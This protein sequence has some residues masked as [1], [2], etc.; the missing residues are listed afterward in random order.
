MEQLYLRL[1]RR[2]K[3]K[4][5]DPSGERNESRESRAIDKRRDSIV[6]NVCNAKSRAD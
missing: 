5:L 3:Y 6:P 4:Q 2:T 1:L